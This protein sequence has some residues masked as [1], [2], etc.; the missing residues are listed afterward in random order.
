MLAMLDEI[1]EALSGRPFIVGEDNTEG[2]GGHG[3]RFRN[4]DIGTTDAESRRRLW[5][6]QSASPC[7]LGLYRSRWRVGHIH[8]FG[9][10]WKPDLCGQ[11]PGRR[12][13]EA[14]PVVFAV[15]AFQALAHVSK[16]DA[17]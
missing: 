14:E 5:R 10:E 12:R 11:P 13:S 15:E 9:V 1:D 4:A 3:G 17:V 16:P 8:R 6:R 7:R 2:F